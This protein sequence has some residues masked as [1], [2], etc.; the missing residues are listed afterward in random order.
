MEPAGGT[1]LYPRL[2][3]WVLPG[4]CTLCYRHVATAAG[5]GWTLLL[6]R[7]SSK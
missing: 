1:T 7:H 6:P 4:Q 3:H 2:L 5:C